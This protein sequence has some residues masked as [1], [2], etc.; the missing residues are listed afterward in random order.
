MDLIDEQH[1]SGLEFLKAPTR[2]LGCIRT[3]PMLHEG[4]AKFIGND[5]AQRGLAEPGRSMQSTVQHRLGL[6]F[7]ERDPKPSTSSGCPR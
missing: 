4:G 7:F 5:P 1:I 3:D 2:S 6:W